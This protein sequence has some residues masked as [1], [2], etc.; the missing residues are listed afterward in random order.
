MTIVRQGLSCVVYTKVLM[1]SF[2]VDVDNNIERR[3]AYE[4]ETIANKTGRV[5]P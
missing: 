1:L 4:Q 5:R 3:N 2:N